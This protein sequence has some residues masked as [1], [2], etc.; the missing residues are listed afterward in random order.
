M[1]KQPRRSTEFI[2]GMLITSLIVIIVGV[3]ALGAEWRSVGTGLLVV[4]VPMGVI[5]LFE[6]A[7]RAIMP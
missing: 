4:G 3:I 1:D 6:L 5:S 7:R 2:T